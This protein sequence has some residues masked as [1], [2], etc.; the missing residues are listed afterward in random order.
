MDSGFKVIYEVQEVK[1]KPPA[2]MEDKDIGYFGGTLSK[3]II[4]TKLF[5]FDNMEVDSSL[6]LRRGKRVNMEISNIH[7]FNRAVYQYYKIR[8]L[9]KVGFRVKRKTVERGIWFIDDWSK[10]Y[11]HWFFDA[12]P[13]LLIGIRF[14]PTFVLILP[15]NFK[16]IR[17]V[18]QSLKLLGIDE[19]KVF[20]MGPWDVLEIRKLAYVTLTAQSGNYNG[21]VV[22]EL[23]N[24][25]LRSIRGRFGQVDSSS[26]SN[27]VFISRRK[28]ISRRIINEDEVVK[29]VE[30]FGFKV[31]VFEELEWEEQV[32]IMYNSKFLV[33]PHGAGLANMLF[34]NDG[35]GI[36][37]FLDVDGYST[38]LCYFALSD[39]L[40]FDYYYQLCKYDEKTKGFWVD[41]GKL[42]ANLNLML[43][44]D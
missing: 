13:R 26:R 3:K 23:R 35:A 20:Y 29:V 37:E 30:S 27:R 36:L 28:A 32:S 11:F 40:N 24:L 31:Y 6:I 33:A 39:I 34:M 10:G 5:Y 12:L 2:N 43:R 41:V 15:Q 1:R 9:E 42:K 25:F 21:E 16:G 17:F 19:S 14:E 22:Q 4:D 44:K 38:N 7:N 8:M 18:E